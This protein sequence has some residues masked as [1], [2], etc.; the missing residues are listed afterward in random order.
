MQHCWQAEPYSSIEELKGN[1][2]AANSRIINLISAMKSKLECVLVESDEITIA[3]V[4]D[5]IDEVSAY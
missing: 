4:G 1:I 2:E 3:T 5:A